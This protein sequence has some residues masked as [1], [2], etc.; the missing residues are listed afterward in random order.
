MKGWREGS[1]ECI[2]LFQRTQVSVHSIH[3]EQLTTSNS[4]SDILSDL[5]GHLYSYIQTEI[6]KNNNL[7]LKPFEKKKDEDQ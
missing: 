5:C 4:C 1:E 7:K 6:I 2:L 3:S